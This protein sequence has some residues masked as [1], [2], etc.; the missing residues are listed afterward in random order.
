VADGS[1][2]E[3]RAFVRKGGIVMALV[4]WRRFGVA[5]FAASRSSRGFIPLIVP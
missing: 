3:M 4:K 5:S 2:R 1:W